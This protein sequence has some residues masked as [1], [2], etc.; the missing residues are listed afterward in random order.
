MERIKSSYFD[1]MLHPKNLS[2]EKFRNA[3]A[4]KYSYNDSGSITPT[5]E[6]FIKHI[7]YEFSI[8][9]DLRNVNEHWRPQVT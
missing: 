3:I 8:S 7:L 5:P 4:K 9:N 2:W 1:K 6:A